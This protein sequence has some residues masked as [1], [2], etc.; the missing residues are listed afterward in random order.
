MAANV[1]ASADTLNVLASF[2]RDAHELDFFAVLRFLECVHANAP[3]FG[4]ASRPVDEAVRL[5]QEPSLAFA[6]S[7]LA[8]F[9]PGDAKRPHRLSTYFFGLFGPQGPLPLH[10]TEFARERERNAEDPTFHAFADLF[11]HRL[12]LLFYR[13][14]ADAEPCTSLDRST[15][16][17]FDAYVGST[18]GIGTPDFRGRDSVPDHAKLYLAGLFAAGAHPAVALQSILEEFFRLPFALEE[19]VGEWLRIPTGDVCLLGRS[20]A[21]LGVDSVVGGQVWSCQHKFRVLC[22]PLGFSDFEAML[23]GSTGLRRLRDLLRNFIGHQFEWDLNLILRAPDVPRLALGMSG[24][25]GWTTWLGD[26]QTNAEARDVIIHPAV[27]LA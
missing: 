21:R 26:R 1:G 2:E 23:P 27:A 20:A 18:F 10:L 16:R 24:A 3:K 7:T 5:G 11:H 14:W 25:L 17:R 19:L 8:S 9:V 12:A 13:A 22:G 15:S 6:P 4:Q